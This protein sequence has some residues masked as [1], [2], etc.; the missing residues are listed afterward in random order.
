MS[1]AGGLNYSALAQLGA[2]WGNLVFGPALQSSMLGIGN[3]HNEGCSIDRAWTMSYKG[4]PGEKI[5]G[6]EDI[7]IMNILAVKQHEKNKGGR[8][9]SRQILWRDTDIC[10]CMHV[11]IYI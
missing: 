8:E 1:A 4:I 5:W 9:G 7:S 11:Y 6:T 3:M 2:L 10:I